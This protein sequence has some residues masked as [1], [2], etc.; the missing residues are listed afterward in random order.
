MAG[1]STNLLIQYEI[2]ILGML[3]NFSSL[4]SRYQG[5]TLNEASLWKKTAMT[6]IKLK[7]KY[8][9]RH[10]T[11]LELRR[12][13]RRKTPTNDVMQFIKNIKSKKS[14]IVI[15]EFTPDTTQRL[16]LIY[17]KYCYVTTSSLSSSL[18]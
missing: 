1:P 5:F 6:T 3:Y 13:I 4:I 7:I 16:L 12:L 10:L 18:C 15:I 14:F 11:T 9:K 17:G 8:T 2:L